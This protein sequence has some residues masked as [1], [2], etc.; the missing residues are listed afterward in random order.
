MKEREQAETKKKNQRKVVVKKKRELD[1]GY[2]DNILSRQ[3]HIKT[4]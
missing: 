1:K 2:E 4:L 3:T